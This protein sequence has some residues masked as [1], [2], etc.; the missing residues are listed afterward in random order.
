METPSNAA[1][2]NGGTLSAQARKL[3]P[4]ASTRRLTTLA[5]V[6]AWSKSVGKLERHTITY[7]AAVRA[8]LTK[9]AMTTKRQYR[10]RT[11]HTDAITYSAVRSDGRQPTEKVRL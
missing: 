8:C 4:A 7:N 1:I 9:M 11:A 6:G 3:S 2:T 5:T 10:R